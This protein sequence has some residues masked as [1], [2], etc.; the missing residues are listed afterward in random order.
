MLRSV[1][2]FLSL[3]GPSGS[4]RSSLPDSSLH[5]FPLPLS[6][7]GSCFFPEL[8]GV[9]RGRFGFKGCR[10]SPASSKGSPS[11]VSSS[12]RESPR[13]SN[14]FRSHLIKVLETSSF[15]EVIT[16]LPRRACRQCQ[17]SDWRVLVSVN[18]SHPGT[19]SS[20]GGGHGHQQNLPPRCCLGAISGMTR[21]WLLRR[22]SRDPPRDAVSPPRWAHR[23]LLCVR[24][25]VYDICI[26]PRSQPLHSLEYETLKE[27]TSLLRELRKVPKR[28]QGKLMRLSGD[29]F[30]GN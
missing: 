18:K 19:C 23:H 21:N 1:L 27:M 28:T 5:V 13:V 8:E 26:I 6:V 17:L 2:T 12:C 25:G 9:G 16:C 3:P 29:S 15:S 14:A 11:L 7:W 22:Q 10:G 30:P 20:P 4:V 24:T